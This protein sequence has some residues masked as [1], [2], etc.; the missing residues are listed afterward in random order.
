M[1]FEVQDFE[2]DVIEKS[3]EQPVLV[4]FWASWC[5]PCR[6]LGPVLETL[7][8]ATDDWTLVKV[9]TDENPDPARRYGIRG[10]PA[11]KLFHEGNVIA[12]FT[13][14]LP[15][16]AVK[17]WLEDHLPSASKTAL[18]QAKD[19]LDAGDTEAAEQLLW[20]VLDSDTDNAEAKVLL[21]RAL[22]F[23]DPLRARALADDADIADPALRQ[24]REAVQ[25]L[26]R[27][28]QL[29]GQ[30]DDLPDGPGH[31]AYRAAIDALGEQDFDSAL[32]RFI[33]VVRTHRDYDDDGA[34][35]ACVALFTLLGTDPPAPQAHRRTFDMALY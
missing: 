20:S 15:K 1:A 14:A 24:T 22:A 16:H 27:L 8:G 3:R 4:D 26:T 6:Q 2:Q 17:S 21:A 32:E 10:I 34:R 11:V 31:D 29:N 9:N 28:L 35:R 23:R 12:E 30:A 25:T 18:E 13:G 33:E 19:A 5:G 7:A